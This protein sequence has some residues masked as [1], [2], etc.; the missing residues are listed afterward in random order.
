M[1][2]LRAYLEMIANQ[3]RMEAYETAIRQVVSEGSIVVDIGTGPGIMAMLA[4]RHGAKHVYAIEPAAVADVARD[5]IRANGFADAI[6][7]IARKSVDVKLPEPADVI[8]SDLRGILPLVEGH[9]PSIIDA[10]TRFL[11]PGGVLI[12]TRDRIFAAVIENV[13]DH[14]DGLIEKAGKV[15]ELDFTS[16]ASMLTG[17]WTRMKSDTARLLSEPSLVAE[18]DYTSVSGPNMRSE[19]ELGVT[20]RGTGHGLALWFDTDLVDGVGFSNAPG[21]PELIYGRMFLPWPSSEALSDGDLVRLTIEAR[22][23]DEAYLWRWRSSIADSEGDVRARFDQSN[24]GSSPVLA[25]RLRRHAESHVPGNWKYRELDVAILRLIDGKRSNREVAARVESI[26][27]DYR[28]A[29]DRV[30]K[31]VDMLS[32]LEPD[33]RREHH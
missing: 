31:L 17:S 11:R 32:D 10:R 26:A 19:L 3:P 14:P 9:L 23:V 27:G 25:S 21:S 28:T 33:S 20:G 16:T 30:T 8:V 13:A 22:Y 29:L 6:T 7:V 18:I 12:P 2:S 5:V 15:S 1:Y 4:C 24:L